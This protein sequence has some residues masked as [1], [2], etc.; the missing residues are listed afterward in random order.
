MA[1]GE[2]VPPLGPPKVTTRKEHLM[3]KGFRGVPTQVCQ[4]AIIAVLGMAG[5]LLFTHS[6]ALAELQS[7]VR[8][9]GSAVDTLQS[10]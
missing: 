6:I 9:L 1:E 4:W 10:R 8:H 5:H 2:L 7:E 3:S